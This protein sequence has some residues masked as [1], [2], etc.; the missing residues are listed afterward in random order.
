MREV[1]A[2]IPR[3]PRGSG[4]DR[5]FPERSS[6]VIAP[7]PSTSFGNEPSRPQFETVRA[8]NPPKSPCS[9]ATWPSWEKVHLSSVRLRTRRRCW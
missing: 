4:P 2:V 7:H 9:A 3:S 8:F 6:A 5:P 1:R